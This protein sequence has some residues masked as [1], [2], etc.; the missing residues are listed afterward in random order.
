METE[1]RKIMCAIDFTDFTDSIISYSLMLCR[2]FHAKLFLVHVL[3]DTDTLL[4]INNT[5]R[6][7]DM[8]NARKKLQE[9]LNDTTVEHE[10]IITRGDSADEIQR[11]ALE[12]KAEMV[13][14]AT[15]GNSGI[16]GFLTGS[17]TEKLMKTLHCPLLVLHTKKHDFIS[18]AIEINIKKVLVGCDFSHDSKLA[19]NYG[20]GMVR[21]FKADL[22]L[23]HVIK[24]T[25]YVELRASDYIDVKPADYVNWRSL[26][27]FKMQEKITENT[28]KRIHDLR[29]QLQRQLYFMVPQECRN[30][31]TPQTTLLDGEP[32]KELIDYARN[33]DMDM[34]VL[35]IRGH[36][37]W[38]KLTVG[39]TTDRVIRQS[40]CPV[41]AVRQVGSP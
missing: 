38:E 29:D 4:H 2:K 33:Q 7:G 14:I 1:P 31:C 24:P 10:I 19:F 15:R 26:D 13:I 5:S 28:H 8:E 17:V 22:Y 34:I 3:I 12:Y 27:Y 20:L 40:P 36:S 18:Q 23:A 21:K 35:G 30:W 6:N 39:S 11:L 25:E 9:L 32:Y 37:L 41:L 16:K